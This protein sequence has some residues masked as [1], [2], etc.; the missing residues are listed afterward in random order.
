MNT[1]AP[2]RIRRLAL[3]LTCGL[4][5]MPAIAQSSAPSS[6][7]WSNGAGGWTPP[8]SMQPMPFVSRGSWVRM[9]FVRQGVPNNFAQ[10][11]NRPMERE[12]PDRFNPNPPIPSP[13]PSPNPTPTVADGGVFF[14]VTGTT[15]QPGTIDPDDPFGVIELPTGTGVSIGAGGFSVGAGLGGWGYGTPTAV[16][17]DASTG[18]LTGWNR[19]YGQYGSFDPRLSTHYKPSELKQMQAEAEAQAREEKLTVSERGLY[20]LAKG[21][22]DLAHDLLTQQLAQTPED[23][24]LIRT[25][26]VIDLLRKQTDAGIK[27]IAGA[28]GADPLLCDTPIDASVYP[29]GDTALR[30]AASEVASIATRAGRADAAMVAAALAQARGDAVVAGRFLDRA[31][32]SGLD[33][34]LLARFRASIAP[35]TKPGADGVV[36]PAR[37]K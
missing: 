24:V 7:V 16:H 14:P 12:L 29:G 21:D 19:S 33:R 10:G 26:G 17:R 30:R 37:A 1:L 11:G 6:G 13:S 35:S 23:L 9:P 25:L 2:S 36:S 22:L 3:V 32:G 8:S 18:Y 34:T 28:Y 20:A 15:G 4:A 27:R 31:A 5:A